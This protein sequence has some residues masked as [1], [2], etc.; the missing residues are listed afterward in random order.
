[1]RYM[2]LLLLLC[3]VGG[4][5]AD[6]MSE[7]QYSRNQLIYL[8]GPDTG[9]FQQDVQN[10]WN[11]YIEKGTGSTEAGKTMNIWFNT[12][13]LKFESPVRLGETT[14]AMGTITAR[15]VSPTVWTSIMLE[16]ETV[17]KFGLDRSSAYMPTSLPSSFQRTESV[18]ASAQESQG[19]IITQSIIA[20]LGV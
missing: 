4:A 12:F 5:A 14:F 8:N 6:A 17:Y 20:K 7:P 2:A 9:S 19:Q 15:N 1:M 18:S 11:T 10:Y 16:R 13:P 3:L